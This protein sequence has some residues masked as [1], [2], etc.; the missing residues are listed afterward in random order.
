MKR[1][2]ADRGFSPGRS[3]RSQLLFIVQIRIPFFPQAF[4]DREVRE[5]PVLILVHSQPHLIDSKNLSPL[6]PHALPDAK[7]EER[8]AGDVV[9]LHRPLPLD[10]A[11]GTLRSGRSTLMGVAECRLMTPPTVVACVLRGVVVSAVLGSIVTSVP[12]CALVTAVR[13]AWTSEV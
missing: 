12:L 3:Q 2:P 10:G 13:A 1:R 9:H 6:V 8:S 7:V 4:K 5:R 11:F